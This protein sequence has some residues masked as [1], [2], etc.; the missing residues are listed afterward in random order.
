MKNLKKLEFPVAT[1]DEAQRGWRLSYQFLEE[2][3]KRMEYDEEFTPSLE[4][5]ELVL[6]AL[7]SY[8]RERESGEPNRLP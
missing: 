5:V 4:G 1:A 7:Q 2:I 6:L 3:E 8:F